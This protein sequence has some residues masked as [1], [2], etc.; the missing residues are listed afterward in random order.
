M[1]LLLHRTGINFAC[2]S[3]VFKC[4]LNFDRRRVSVKS[5]RKI[6]VTLGLAFV[7]GFITRLELMFSTYIFCIFAE[8]RLLKKTKYRRRIEMA[9]VVFAGR[10][11]STFE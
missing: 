5:K 10:K 3:P 6:L 7:F 9:I 8:S 1:T 2:T 4:M 11:S